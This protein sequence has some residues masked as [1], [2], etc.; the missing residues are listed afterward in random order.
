MDTATRGQGLGVRFGVTSTAIGLGTQVAERRDGM[1]IADED[2]ADISP[3]DAHDGDRSTVGRISGQEDL[4]LLTTEKFGRAILGQLAAR[5][6]PA[7]IL[8][9]LAPL[10]RIDSR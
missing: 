9:F 10:R 1:A 3:S 4:R 6:A 7:V 8:A 5:V 2:L